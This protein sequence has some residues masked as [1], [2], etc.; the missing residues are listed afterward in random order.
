M[1]VAAQL[2]AR[3]V[4]RMRWL[5]PPGD[6]SL[7]V[8][9]GILI[10]VVLVAILAPVLAPYSPDALHS[11]LMQGPS[12]RFLLGTDEL[13][14]DVL[15]RVIYGTQNSLEIGFSA[16]TLAMLV[17][18]PLGL[19]AGRNE[20]WLST[21]IMRITDVLLGFPGIVI[22]MV[23]SL[24]SNDNI[25]GVVAA[26]GVLISP[27]FV[28]VARSVMIAERGKLYVDAARALG[29]RTRYILLRSVLPNG[30]GPLLVQY[31]LAI[32]NSILL[33]AGLSFLGLGVQPPTPSW[34]SMIQEGVD[35][36]TINSWISV[37]PGIA[38]VIVVFALNATADGI[39]RRG[40]VSGYATNL[41][42]GQDTEN[43]SVRTPNA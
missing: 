19:L 16:A 30:I 27:A 39:A 10:A 20:A 17:G 2:R 26:I 21:A 36:L 41:I 3:V 25:I 4:N 12:G 9:V 40:R 15:S 29:A 1:T 14:R 24:V 7:R 32:T 31:A 33:I 13:G 42:L 43:L 8:G 38:I 35:Y 22:V 5:F 37:A 18:V 6:V 11:S 34:G 28:R 23:I